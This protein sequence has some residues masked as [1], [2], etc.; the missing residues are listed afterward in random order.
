MDRLRDEP[1]AGAGLAGEEDGAV[2]AADGFDHLEHGEHPLAAPDD[3]R[4][5]VRQAERA[6]QQQVL[7]P[8]LP[9][10]DLLPHFHL[11]QIDVERLAQV[12]ACAEPHRLHGGIGRREGGDHDAEDV[13]I[14]LLRGAQHVDAAQVGH[15]DVGNQEIDRLVL[16]QVDGGAAVL[17]QEHLVPL[18]SQHDRQQLAHRALIVDDED[19]GG[20]AIGRRDGGLRDRVHD[21]STAR[22]GRRTETV[23][24][25]PGCELT[26]ISPL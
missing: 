24:P 21:A 10:L 18:A 4:E 9:V 5:L 13:L 16:E 14:D 26:W 20:A 2:G 15:L 22:A 1:L 7:L 3:V 25:L 17:G 6:L 12:V 19:A 11:E 8:E 23:V